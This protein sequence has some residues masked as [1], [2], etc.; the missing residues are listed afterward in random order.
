VLWVFETEKTVDRAISNEVALRDIAPPSPGIE[1]K[2][3]LLNSL[4]EVGVPIYQK[5]GLLL[6]TMVFL[7]MS[8]ESLC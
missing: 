6:V 5:F 4:K 1:D 2:M 3:C 8:F 7:A